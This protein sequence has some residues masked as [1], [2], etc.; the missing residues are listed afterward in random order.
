MTCSIGKGHGAPGVPAI[1][2]TNTI[3]PQPYV[4]PATALFSIDPRKGH[5]E[6]DHHCSHESGRGLGKDLGK[7]G[8]GT[9][10]SNTPS[11]LARS[12]PMPTLLQLSAG[13][14]AEST[15][16]NHAQTDLRALATPIAR[17]SRPEDL[18]LYLRGVYLLATDCKRFS[19][20]GPYP[21]LA[22]CHTNRDRFSARRPYPVLARCSFL[23]HTDC[24][25][26]SARRPYPVL[27]RCSSLG[28]RL[29]EVLGPR[30]LPCTCKVP[31]QS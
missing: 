27:A 22:R 19:A 3:D 30:T 11:I 18:T 12:C 2:P 8:K 9:T 21:V 14:E 10:L 6:A 16:S 17:G 23:S 5:T 25:R 26:F 29:Q 20:R 1:K 28:Y 13:L 15:N 24:K 31:H 7:H 4:Q